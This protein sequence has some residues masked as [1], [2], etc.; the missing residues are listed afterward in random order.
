MS[1]ATHMG[2]ITWFLLPFAQPSG[3]YSAN[4]FL[5][6]GKKK[7]RN[8][9][10]V[11]FKD[12]RCNYHSKSYYCQ[13]FKLYLTPRKGSPNSC[14]CTQVVL[15]SK[16]SPGILV[17]CAQ[18]LSVSKSTQKNS[19]PKG[20]KIFS[21]RS[22]A[23]WK[24]FIVSAQ[25]LYAPNWIIDITR[26]QNGCG[27]CAKNPMNSKVPQQATWKTADTS[28]W[29]LRSTKYAQPNGDYT[30]NCYLDLW[31]TPTSENTV[32]F[33][34]RKCLYRSRS[35][36]CQPISK[37]HYKPKAPAPPPARRIFR[38]SSLKSGLKEEIYYF[39]QGSRVPSLT[40]RT[41]NVFRTVGNVN[42]GNTKKAWPGFTQ[43]DHF[44]V[45]WTGVVI[46]KVGGRY[47][48]YIGSDD[49]SK[50]YIDKSYIINND[51]LHAWRTKA[52][53][54]KTLV[55]GQ[56]RLRLEFFEKNG[57]AG[58]KFSYKGPDTRKRMVV[59]PRSA[60]K[61]N[62]EQGFKEEI[63]YLGSKQRGV[64]KVPDLNKLLLCKG[65]FLV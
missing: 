43:K 53:R 37:K 62:P 32:Q 9:N 11:S 18:C 30:A 38:W 64:S 20:Y 49:G 58:M 1:V 45:R 42:Y 25:P 5:D 15:A 14:K 24:T 4:C 50:L 21:P 63:Y 56:H 48:F 6:L 8:E 23:D 60:V 44:A 40:G 27:G 52:S 10:H 28:P 57:H 34:D 16:Y 12:E 33:N 3:E 47:T 2:F 19:C 13:K 51:G 54:A 7:L 55:R 31:R 17:K 29:W 39:K 59:V 22:R 35:Y 41:S 36:Y 65:S 26:P 46:L 61:Y